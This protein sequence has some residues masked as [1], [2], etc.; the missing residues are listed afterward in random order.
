MVIFEIPN[1]V[2]LAIFYCMLG[3]VGLCALTFAVVTLAM[4][5][6]ELLRDFGQ[7]IESKLKK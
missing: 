3:F 1:S 4:L 7:W 5:A 6:R 2:S